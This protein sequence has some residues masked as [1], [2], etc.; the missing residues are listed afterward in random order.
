MSADNPL[1]RLADKL[2]AD[3]SLSD[4]EAQALVAIPFH[5]KEY[6]ENSDILRQGDRSSQCC[7]VVDGLLCRFKVVSNGGR[8]IISLHI[9]QD[10]PDLHGLY[11]TYADHFLGTL[12]RSTLAFL[13]H[14][15]VKEAVAA[16]PRLGACMW[17]E[18]LIDASILGEWIVNSGRR[19]AGTR[20]AHMICELAL[21]YKR[22]GTGDETGF[23][24]H[25]TQMNIADAAGLSIVHV[26]RMLQGLRHSGLI[27]NQARG[28]MNILDWQ[29]LVREGEFDATYLHLAPM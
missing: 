4:A 10:M 2:S 11:L 26:N 23:P 22:A 20:I 17:R 25:L 18:T 15:S 7:L 6:G 1:F 3:C 8:Q 5:L 27:G 21:R 14:D 19:E 16:H 9:P 29:G 12:P 28:R 13:P 24:W